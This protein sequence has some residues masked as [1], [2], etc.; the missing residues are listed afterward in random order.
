MGAEHYAVGAE[1]RGRRPTLHCGYAVGTSPR[2][3]SWLVWGAVPQVFWHVTLPNIRWGL[4]YGVI[5]T[6][7][8]AMGEFGAVS[9]IS[10]AR[11]DGWE[12]PPEAPALS[13]RRTASAVAVACRVMLCRQ[14]R[15]RLR[16]VRCGVTRLHRCQQLYLACVCWAQHCNLLPA[17]PP[18]CLHVYDHGACLQATSLGAPRR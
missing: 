18:A 17:C 11:T 1:H 12:R 10:G 6:N 15:E 9:V 5:L 8:R 4:L 16:S 3:T 2:L 14:S 13:L 7:A